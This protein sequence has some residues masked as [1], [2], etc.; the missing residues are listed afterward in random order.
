[1]QY[2]LGI[3]YPEHD[4]KQASLPLA[5]SDRALWSHELAVLCWRQSSRGKPRRTIARNTLNGWHCAIDLLRRLRTETLYSG[6]D[7]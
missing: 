1:M 7:W 2:E 3:N 4:S 6:A 5:T